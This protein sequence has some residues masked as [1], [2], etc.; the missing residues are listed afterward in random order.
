MTLRFRNHRVIAVLIVVAVSPSSALAIDTKR[1]D[2]SAFKTG[3]REMIS[4]SAFIKLVNKKLDG[5]YENL[6]SVVTSC[7]SG[8]FAA[9]S[10]LVRGGLKGTWSIATSSSTKKI[11]NDRF[12]LGKDVKQKGQ[13]GTDVS[14][15]DV[16]GDFMHGYTA[17]YIRKLDAGKNT[18]SAKTLHD[19]AENKNH[20]DSSPRYRSSGRAADDMTVYGGDKANRAIIISEPT[21][22]PKFAT[23]TKLTDQ[24]YKE[25]K[26][27]GYKDD[28]DADRDDGDEIAFLRGNADAPAQPV[29][30]SSSRANLE[31]ALDE[32]RAVIDKDGHENKV[33]VFMFVDAHGGYQE[34][35][36]AYRDGRIDQPG[37]GVYVADTSSGLPDSTLSIDIFADDAGLLADLKEELPRLTHG[38]FWLDDPQVTRADNAYIAFSTIEESFV[39][40]DTAVRVAINGLEI[41]SVELDGSQGGDYQVFIP[42]TV[43]DS[44]LPSIETLQVASVSFQLPTSNDYFR[45][46]VLEDYLDDSFPHLDYGIGIG[47]ILSGANPIPESSS[48]ALLCIGFAGGWRRRRPHV[49]PTT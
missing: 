21:S 44:V 13:D 4:S 2:Q 40:G 5:K 3:K 39:T 45:L 9:R 33:N 38:G 16:G 1:E 19:T 15:L 30:R 34:R 17:Q 31:R 18:V 26:D 27:A 49:L 22:H 23:G 14:G 41:G 42:D 11:C 12:L 25:L 48:A 10:G 32:V 28:E 8:E 7:K 36:V 46:S 20:D 24:L 6:T 47:S 43:L 37:G 35:T 29:D